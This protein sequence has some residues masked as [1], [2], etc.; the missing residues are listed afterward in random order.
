MQIILESD[1][2]AADARSAIRPTKS[3]LAVADLGQQLAGE[4]ANL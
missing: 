3:A 1:Y 2:D 4:S